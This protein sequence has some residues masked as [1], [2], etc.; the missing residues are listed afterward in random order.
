MEPSQDTRY[1]GFW[2]RLWAT[3]IDVIVLLLIIPPILLWMYGIEYFDPDAMLV[4]SKTMF[5][6]MIWYVFP[7][8]AMIILWRY[9]S[10][11]PG[12]MV[13]GVRI[14]DAQTLE[15]PS[16][17]QCVVRYFAYLV[18]TIPLGLGFLWIG[19]DRRKQAWHDKLANTVVI[20]GQ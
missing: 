2:I 13:F 18:S 4:R 9:R 1:A 19:F 8:I 11:T 20:R 10:A 14:V 7:A 5:E 3:V 15:R 16:T 17:V 6:Y 12:K